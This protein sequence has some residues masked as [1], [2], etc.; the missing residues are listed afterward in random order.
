MKKGD[1]MPA[2]ATRRIP[3]GTAYAATSVNTTIFRVSALASSGK[4]QYVTYYDGEGRVVVGKR[5]ADGGGPWKLATTPASG[6]VRDAHNGTVLGVSADG[7]VHLSYDHH[8]H[9]L[10]Y[11][12]SARPEEA[13]AFGPQQPM[14]GKTE[15]RVTYPQFVA[16]PDGALYFFY[17]DGASGNGRLCLNRYDPAPKAW[18]ALHHPLVDG[19]TPGKAVSNPY[20]WRPAFGPKGDLHLAW[21]WRD[22][23]DARTNHD[24]CYACSADG[25]RT[26]RRSD[27]TLQP[28]PITPENAEVADPVPTG[29]NLIN[30]CSSAVDGQGRPHLAHY[31][32]DENGVPQYMHLWHD[33]KRWRRN[34]VSR[35][36]TPFSLSGGGSLRIPISRPEIAVARDGAVYL[37]TRDEELGG[38]IRL[39]RSDGDYS[40]WTATDILREDLGSWEP[41]YDLARFRR[42]GILSLFVLATQQGNH[43]TV[44]ATPPREASVLEVRLGG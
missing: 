28:T 10:R 30:Q 31:H 29:S 17:R 7:Y 24:L 3:I 8:G 21:C 32:N 42:T 2:P 9:P 12:V 15:G 27:G 6:N 4:H 38:G 5:D 16:A 26:W 39:Y 20:W 33:G 40:G 34:T 1:A 23:G 11:R 19:V 43:E 25:G 22:S 41:S 36:K 18:K 44:T 14:T 13:A 35:R 37:V